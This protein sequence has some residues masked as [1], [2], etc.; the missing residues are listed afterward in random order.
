MKNEKV[1][2]KEAKKINKTKLL[3]VD[4]SSNNRTAISYWLSEENYEILHAVE[5]ASALKIVEAFKPDIILLDYNLPGMDG[6][7]VCQK[8]RS[9]PNLPFI[10]I[11]M[12]SSYTPEAN[13]MALEQGADEFIIMPVMPTELKSRLRAM[14]RLKQTISESIELVKENKKLQELDKIKSNFISKVSHELRTPLQSV[15]GYTDIL[16]E[17]LQGELNY[18]QKLMVKQ[19]RESGDQ[20]LS[21][22]SQVLDFES[23]EK[24]EY[25]VLTEVFAVESVFNYLSQ[26]L[27]PITMKKK[28]NLNFVLDNQNIQLKSDKNIIHKVLLN[29]ISN[30]IKFSKEGSKILV[31]VQDLDNEFVEFIVQ[32]EG[33]GILNS[34]IAYIFDK[35]W[36][37]DDSITRS[38]GGIGI[39]LSLVK[40]LLTIINGQITVESKPNKGSTF[41]IQLP[42]EF[43]QNAYIR[44][45]SVSL[46]SVV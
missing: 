43:K 44:N 18:P 13:V 19:I 29:V 23:I 4:D 6:I 46:K 7:E 25:A 24:G 28:I 9:N 45:E 36:Q 22:I 8:I 32:D 37:G 20:L 39:G 41:K 2:L 38:Y 30:S 11:V 17:G 10:P 1:I 15:L 26:V 5:G 35:F 21:L 12:M 34:N 33:I 27:T 3:I 14:L 40:N 16:L 42:K 31:G